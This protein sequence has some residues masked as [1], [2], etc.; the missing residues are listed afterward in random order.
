MTRH[1]KHVSAACGLLIAALALGPAALAADAA[2]RQG[3]K[4][5]GET[6]QLEKTDKGRELRRI[7]TEYNWDDGLVYRYVH[8]ADGNLVETRVSHNG[9]RPDDTELEQAFALVWDDDEVRE[10]RRRQAGLDINGGFT[11]REKSGACALPSRCIQVFL[12]DGENVVR[13]MLVD[14]RTNKIV[15]RDYVPVSAEDQKR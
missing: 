14:L 10:I 11:Y 1:R 5:V 8:D 12:F 7:R 6:T 13:H 15:N 3:T 4:F 2:T 9:L